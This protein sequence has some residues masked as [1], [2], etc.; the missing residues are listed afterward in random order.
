MAEK[1][2]G[3]DGGEE[4][5]GRSEDVRDRDEGRWLSQSE[6]AWAERKEKREKMAVAVPQ[7]A[8]WG[9]KAERREDPASYRGLG[10]VVPWLGCPALLRGHLQRPPAP[11]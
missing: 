5:R 3:Q 9:G 6:T 11:G 2:S 10:L 7:R 4:W 8:R 1:M